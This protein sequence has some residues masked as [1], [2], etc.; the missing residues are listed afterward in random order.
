MT[1]IL[2][3]LLGRIQDPSL[4]E[5]LQ[6]EVNRLRST[7][8]FGLV[9]EKHM[10]ENVRLYSHPVRRG[11]RVEER[12]GKTE[13]T[14]L[15]KRVRDGKAT[16]VDADGRESV[17]DIDELVVIRQFGEPIYPGLT[18]VGRI[19]RG[20][21]KPFHTV[22]NGE[23]Y[24]ALETLLYAY[25]GKVDCIYIDPPYNTGAKDW[26]YNNDYVA[27][28]DAYRHSKWLSFLA[29]RLALAKRL[30]NPEGSV[31]IVTI[32]EKEYLHLGL[33]LEQMFSSARM[34]MV[35]IRINPS[36]VARLGDFRRSDEFAF[37]VRFGS[38]ELVPAELGGEWVGMERR[39][40]PRPPAWNKLRRTGTNAQR[41][42]RPNLFYPLFIDESAPKI[43]SVGEPLPLTADRHSIVAPAGTVAVW[44]IRSDGSEGNWQIGPETLRAAIA[45][46]FVMLGNA[47]Q[48]G[49]AVYY[50]KAG[51][52]KR[53]LAD[54]EEV[55]R[56]PDGSLQLES[57]DGNEASSAVIPTT[58]WLSASHDSATHGSR[59]I[60]SLV[61][62]RKFPYPK[63]LYAVEDSLR[64]FVSRKSTAL[65]VDFFGGSG[66][67]AHAVMRLNK[68]DGG[69]RRCIVVTNNEVSEDEAQLLRESGIFPGDPAW[70]AQGIYQHITR[71]RIEAAITGITHT[72]EPVKGE[73]KFIDEFPMSEGFEENVEFLELTY[74]DRNDVSRGKEFEAIAPLLWMKVGARGEMIV[75]QQ[76]NFSAPAK[77]LYAVLFDIDAWPKFIDEIR[78]REDLE[79]V[80][81]V[82]DS[83]AMYQQVVAE[84]PV[85]LETTMLYEDYLRNFEINM[86]GAQ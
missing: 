52:Q 32:D 6:V 68:Q 13:A 45:S 27:A 46:G 39:L 22:I 51:E 1:N 53:V 30:L 26:K 31:L 40:G 3:G 19:E 73:Y 2:D 70:E 76:A 78:G 65:V 29:R 84:L 20:G 37:F 54:F 79:H 10:P 50:L 41:Q 64:F 23:N 75:E 21:D 35:S 18:S 5:A 81:I 38:Q 74:L 33:L 24:H 14:W 16:L 43:V 61:P 77:A 86:G 12:S 49:F 85:E 34:Q 56:R 7:K 9:F 62:G 72:G 57:R 58:Q 25:E 8:D 55:G 15:V 47:T 83:L 69:Q 44:P 59:L 4:R 42:D 80:F 63:S 82:T 11:L 17:R 66:T 48:H 67:T 28:D 71:P 36:G 60:Q